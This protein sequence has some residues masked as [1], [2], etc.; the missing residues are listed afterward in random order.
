MLSNETELVPAE[1]TAWEL[2]ALS[3]KHK[4]AAALLAQGTSRDVIATFCGWTPEYVTMLGRQPLFQQYIKEMSALVAVRLEA[5]F[6]R[7]VDV[8]GEAMDSNNTVEDR[9]RGAK[10]Q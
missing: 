1:S 5:M 3:P 2:K 7:S 6:D 8:I 9:L 10:L 4:Q